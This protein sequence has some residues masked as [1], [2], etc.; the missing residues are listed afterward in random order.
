MHHFLLDII[1]GKQVINFWKRR[2]KE[3]SNFILT[4]ACQ[5]A[6]LF[7]NRDRHKIGEKDHMKNPEGKIDKYG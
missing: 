2:K 5:I 1:L 4:E 7:F 6:R 3:S